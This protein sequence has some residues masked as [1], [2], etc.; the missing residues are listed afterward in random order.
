MTLNYGQEH[1][2]KAVTESDSITEFNFQPLG[3]RQQ[4]NSLFNV[5]YMFSVVPATGCNLDVSV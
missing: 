1:D 2:K 5:I 4:G 3:E